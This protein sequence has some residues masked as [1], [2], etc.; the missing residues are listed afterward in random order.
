M[1][2]AAESGGNTY[3]FPQ[4]NEKLSEQIKLRERL[5]RAIERDELKVFF[6]PLVSGETG[7]IIGAEALLR[8][9]RPEA[10]YVSPEFFVPMLEEAGLAVR[11]GDWVMRTALQSN[12]AW[13]KEYD[14]ELFIAVN[15]CSAQ[16]ADERAVEKLDAM[17]KELSFEP[18]YL[19]LEISE[20]TLMRDAPAGLTLLHR[21][22]DLG[23]M[24]SMDNFGTGYSSLSYLNRFPIDAVKI[25]RSFIQDTPNDTEALAITRTIIAMAHAL[26]LKV[27][28]AGVESASQ[29]NFLRRARCDVLQGYRFSQGVSAEDFGRLL[30]ENQKPG[31]FFTESEGPERL[32]LVG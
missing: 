31:S 18:R 21:L 9:F 19:N 6:Q 5:H 22:N 17:M 3:R 20:E 23:I 1:Y 27:V 15:Y 26:N 29:V 13:R 24:L 12:I 7:R 28:A 32:H 16:T 25:D 4:T 14:S 30:V 8:W 11:V 10:G 2:L